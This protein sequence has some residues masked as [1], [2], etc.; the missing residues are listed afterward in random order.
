MTDRFEDLIQQLGHFLEMDLHVDHNRA[1]LLQIH[2]TIRIQ[3]QLDAAQEK[4][5][6]AS[7]AIEVPPGKF[8]ENVLREALKT[9]SLP[10][11]R[12]AILSYLPQNNSLVLHQMFPLDILNGERLAGYFGAF[13]EQ[14]ES[15]VKAITNGQAAPI[16]VAPTDSGRKPFGLKP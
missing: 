7:F 8:R 16:L 6:M 5:L 12:P 11:P 15:Y 1:C 4:L 9:N 2:D 14:V 13:L 3:L 10:D